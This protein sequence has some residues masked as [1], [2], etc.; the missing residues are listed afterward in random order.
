VTVD[1]HGA[2]R[3]VNE[4]PDEM[5]IDRLISKTHYLS[6]DSNEDEQFI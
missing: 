1:R 3:I 5:P 6:L 4:F 2:S